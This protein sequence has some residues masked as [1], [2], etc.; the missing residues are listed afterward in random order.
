MKEIKAIIWDCDGCLIDSEW[1]ACGNAAQVL[2]EIGYPITT[3]EF[4]VRFAGQGRNHIFSTIAQETGKNLLERYDE[5]SSFDRLFQ[6]FKA[7]L[8]EIEGITSL[9]QNIKMPMAIASGSEYERLEFSLR[10]TNLF[11]HFAPHIYSASSIKRG[12]PAPDIFLYAANKLDIA[13]QNCLVIED[14]ENG[15]RAGK[16]AGMTV[17]GFTGGSH[18]KNKAAH[19]E[20]LLSLGADL[21][22]D[23]MRALPALM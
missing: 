5:I 15:V 11:D 22:F 10:H 14:S 4:V 19:K 18:I 9:L 12:K 21:V 2:T 17:F 8:Q 6:L 20:T 3:D 1:I 13:P 23:E 16:A 7:E